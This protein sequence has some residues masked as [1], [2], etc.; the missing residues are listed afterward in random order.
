MPGIL[1]SIIQHRLNV[2]PEKKLVRQRR[3]VFTP[4][5]NKAVMDEVNKLLTANFIRE[6]H[7][8]KW[9]ANVVMIKKGNGKW[10]MCVDFTDLNQA[11]PKDNFPL[12]RIDQ[13]VDSTA[14]HK[15]LTFMDAFFGYNQIQVAKEDQEKTAIV[16]SQGLYCY[17]VIPFRLKNA[18]ATYQRLVNQMF[19]K[20]IGRNVEV[21]VDDMLVRSKEEEDHLDD[22]KETFNTLRQYNMKLNPS[23]CAF[24]V[25]SGKFLEFIVSQTGIEANPEKFRAILEMSSPRTTKEVQSLTRRVEALN[26]FVSKATNKCLP[27]FKTLKKAFTWTEECETTFQELKHY[28]SNPPLLS[29]SKEGEDLVLYLAV[30]VTTVSVA[31]IREENKVQLP[32]YYVSQAF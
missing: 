16:T 21:Y 6:V 7:Y 1:V 27:F 4:E 32:V 10:R 11:Y 23:K 9:L 14:G 17:K 24:E 13:L 26:R 22:I 30:S 18:G 19:E 5:R 15:L 12:P 25:S 31:L 29:P 2:D 20:Q 28:L 3:R 8:P